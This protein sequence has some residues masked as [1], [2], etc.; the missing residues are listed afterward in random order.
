M[1]VEGIAKAAR[2]PGL[3]A[4]VVV[5]AHLEGP[6]LAPSRRGAHDPS[7]LR[8]PDPTELA[9][10]LE[11][12][13]NTLRMITLAPEVPGAPQVIKAAVKAGIIVS[14]GHTDADYDTVRGAFDIGARHLTHCGNAM[15]PL[16]HRH[17]GAIGAAL[18]DERVTIELI[19]DGEHL[20]QGFLRLVSDAAPGRFVAITDA[21]SATGMPDGSYQLGHLPVTVADGRVTLAKH[22]GTLAGSVLT[23]DRAVATL[24]ASG[25]SIQDAIRAA[26]ST[27]G[28]LVGP[29]QDGC[30]RG[31]LA[32]GYCADLV[33]LDERLQA[34]A[35]M[36]GG[37]VVYDALGYFDAI[38]H[39]DQQQV[40][41]RNRT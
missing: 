13:G 36:V 16:S 41:H 12:A 22:P 30:P 5:G 18:T 1:T 3:G 6:W 38:E 10:L 7:A 15:A 28:R 20:H 14:V 39:F 21:T 40:E 33:V 8:P 2:T 26:S 11:I 37:E 29:R 31:E 4:A 9:S 34:Q 24:V 35:T 32:P 19:A 17:P 25:I 23:M 27:P